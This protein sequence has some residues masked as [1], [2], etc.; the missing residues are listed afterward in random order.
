MTAKP[1]NQ[2]LNKEHHRLLGSYDGMVPRWRKRGP[3]VCERFWGGV[4][5]D[6]S[7]D[8]CAWEFLTHDMVRSKAYRW[9]EDGIARICDRYQTMIFALA[10]GNARDPILKERM[11]GLTGNEGNHHGE[12][13]KEYRFY[14]D[15]TPT[16]TY[17][18]V[19]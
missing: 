6:C 17:M 2:P 14:L 7:S 1:G 11:F 19:L 18:K 15:N 10:M 3:Y 5:E 12:D 8:G 9:G 4:R 16:H 13:V